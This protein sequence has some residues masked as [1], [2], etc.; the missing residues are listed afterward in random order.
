MEAT[1]DLDK[2]ISKVQKLLR[3]A[4]S[5]NPNEAQVFLQKAQQLMAKHGIQVT[6]SDEEKEA[7]VDEEIKSKTKG[8]SH[9]AGSIAVTL[10]KHFRCKVISRCKY[11]GSKVLCFIG[12]TSEVQILKEVYDYTMRV[13]ESCFQSYLK[14]RKAK[15]SIANSR[16]ES[17]RL[18]NDYLMGFVYGIERALEAN[19]REYALIVCLPNSVSEYVETLKLSKPSP[20]P[21]ASRGDVSAMA[22]GMADGKASQSR[23]KQIE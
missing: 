2:V 11:D 7:V 6:E 8:V 1:V 4:K 16:S 5:D 17:I 3:K 9:H 18:K 20:S 22:R 21:I 12:R 19:E 23:R 13:Y 15:G 14:E 10:A